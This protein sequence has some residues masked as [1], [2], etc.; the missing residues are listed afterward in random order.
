MGS[1]SKRAVQCSLRKTPGSWIFQGPG[2][3]RLPAAQIDHWGDYS[4]N[5]SPGKSR[6]TAGLGKTAVGQVPEGTV[7]RSQTASLSSLSRISQLNM[8]GFSLLYSSIFFSTSGVVTCFKRPG[9]QVL[10]PSPPSQMWPTSSPL[11]QAERS[12]LHPLRRSLFLAKGSH[13]RHFTFR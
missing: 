9:R 12:L 10:I 5:G 11:S 6:L 1:T 4:F 13:L 3:S 7:F 2:R 8:P